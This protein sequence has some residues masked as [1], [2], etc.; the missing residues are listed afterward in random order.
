MTNTSSNLPVCIHCGT[1]R[2]ADEKLCPTCGKPWIDVS[3]DDAKAVAG[4][5]AA[6]APATAEATSV[7]TPAA[8]PPP[9]EDTEEFGFDEW[10]LP[11]DPKRSKVWWL[12]PV[13]LF[14]GLVALW[15]G[16]FIDRDGGTASSAIVAVVVPEPL[17]TTTTSATTTTDTPTTTLST[18]TT[19]TIWYPP[20]DSWNAVGDPIPVEEL[21]LGADGIGPIDI[22]DPITDSAGAL[23]ASL[24]PA[25]SAGIDSAACPDSEWYWLQWG[26]LRGIFDGYTQSSKFI[27]YRYEGEGNDAPDPMLETLSGVR[28][29]DSVEQ[30]QDIYDSYTVSF[31]VIEGKDYF[32]LLDGGDLLL[33][34]P[35]TS[36][37][38]DGTTEG[39][40]S[41]DPC[42]SSN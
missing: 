33:W 14:V 42:S 41:P 8:S 7:P 6:A 17:S 38:P 19:T 4:A 26:D 28:L 20:A 30:L 9:I 29:G 5:T 27:A 16:V 12:I 11:P 37:Q 23:V 24:G 18:T 1:A 22:G 10:T 39:I 36:T 40:Y 15:M 32:R 13:V 21:G 31:E 35:V 2:P 34:G 25:Q 3:V